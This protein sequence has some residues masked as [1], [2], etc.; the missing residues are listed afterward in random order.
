MDKFEPRI[1]IQANAVNA[2]SDYSGT[3]MV[4]NWYAR[5]LKIFANIQQL[6]LKS[7]RMFILYGAGHLK[8][9]RQL[10]ESDKNLSIY[11]NT[12]N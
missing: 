9:L 1:Y 5:N 11:M 3:K 12:Y 7:K 6:A 10:I 8:I 4:A 2:N